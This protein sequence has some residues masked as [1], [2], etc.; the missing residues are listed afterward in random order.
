VRR[1]R[2][3]LRSVSLGSHPE[4]NQSGA[5]RRALAGR[6][7]AALH[8]TGFPPATSSPSAEPATPARALEGQRSGAELEEQLARTALPEAAGARDKARPVADRAESAAHAAAARVG[9]LRA[10]LDQ[11]ELEAQL[12]EQEYLQAQADAV[13]ARLASTSRT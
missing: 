3:A 2:C 8:R 12:G 7:S 9:R 11:A 10:D 1:P 5:L 13:Q 6:L 4:Q